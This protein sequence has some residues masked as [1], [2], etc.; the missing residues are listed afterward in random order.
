[1]DPYVKTHS[2]KP[3]TGISA[4]DLSWVQF[5]SGF[6]L[7]GDS[8]KSAEK[9]WSND[10]KNISETKVLVLGHHGSRTSTSAALLN[11]LPHLQMTI[12]SARKARYGHPNTEV[13]QRLRIKKTPVLKTEDWGSI[14]LL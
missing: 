14:W 4:N 1:M 5:D 9:I 10:F 7:P 3:Q 11:K 8:T 2:W 6:L 12:A 13:L